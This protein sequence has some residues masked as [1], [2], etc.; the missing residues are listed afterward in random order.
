MNKIF[1]TAKDFAQTL[2]QIHSSDKKIVV[3]AGPTAS[4]KSDFAI[5]LAKK[6][7]GCIINADSRQ[8][9]KEIRIGTATPDLI[10]PSTFAAAD[11]SQ[12]GLVNYGVLNDINHY[13]YA[14]KSIFQK[15]TLV[16]YINDLKSLISQVKN[17][18]ERI[19]IVGGTGLYID[20]YIQNYNLDLEFKNSDRE[21]LNLMTIEE[22]QD[23]LTTDQLKKL[24]QSDR[25]NKYRLI[26]AIERNGIEY[27]KGNGVDSLYYIISPSLSE[28]E[29]KIKERT[30]K[31]L[32]KGLLEENIMI[33]KLEAEQGQLSIV[34]KTIG[35]QEFDDYFTGSSTIEA[36]K[37]LISLHS[38]QYAKRQITWFKRN[39]Q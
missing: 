33:R 9:Y 39:T 7:N 1:I 20:A 23:K 15:V 18:Y 6:L 10:F 27:S 4:G 13:L 31:M 26:R 8:I 24:N 29:I 5:S 25:I 30:D 19:F 12:E 34:H 36:T 37:C 35:Y 2:E 21:E 14:Y 17:K 3:I 22:L 28:L 32:D 16:D 38:R 11:S